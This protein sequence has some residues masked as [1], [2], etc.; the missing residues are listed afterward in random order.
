MASSTR[1]WALPGAGA[2]LGVLIFL[3]I[4][5]AILHG[6]AP[7]HEAASG[8]VPVD[9]APSAVASEGT[10]IVGLEEG[11]VERLPV[12]PQR[13]GA[14]RG[15]SPVTARA[16][17]AVCVVDSEERPLE[18]AEVSLQ[19]RP[20]QM[21]S[22]SGEA[23]LEV[24]SADPEV[25]ELAV[26]R[27]GFVAVRQLVSRFEPRVNVCLERG[28]TLTGVVV[29][30]REVPVADA[31][32]EAWEAGRELS[33]RLSSG[34]TD[35]S[36]RFVLEGLESKPIE[37]SVQPPAPL[38]PMVIRPDPRTPEPLHIVLVAGVPMEVLLLDPRGTPCGGVTV[39]A[40]FPERSRLAARTAVTDASG[41]ARLE[42]LPGDAG[43]LYLALRG[44]GIAPE[45]RTV[46]SPWPSKIEIA[47]EPGATIRGYFSGELADWG[48]IEVR[49]LVPGVGLVRTQ[50]DVT[51]AFELAHLPAD[52]PVRLRVA[53]ERPPPSPAL[54]MPPFA[55]RAG[56]VR[57]VRI[58]LPC[59]HRVE[60]LV[61]EASGVAIEECEVEAR[62]AGSKRPDGTS[63][64]ATFGVSDTEGRIVFLL[65]PGPWKV[66]AASTLH[67]PQELE[68]PPPLPDS[69]TLTLVRKSEVCGRVLSLCGE[70]CAQRQVRAWDGSCYRTAL[71]TSDGCFR[72]LGIAP[73]VPIDLVVAGLHGEAH[74]LALS[75]FVFPARVPAEIV[76]AEG[77]LEGRLVGPDE[78][79]V[80]GRV[81]LAKRSEKHLP[82]M[83]CEA[84]LVL[85]CD[86]NGSFRAEKLSLGWWE[87]RAEA[88]ELVFEPLS[89]NLTAAGAMQ[90]VLVR[91]EHACWLE[92]RA[93]ERNAVRL[94]LHDA[95]GAPL[96]TDIYVAPAHSKVLG[97][98]LPGHYL[99]EIRG[100]AGSRQVD[101]EIS[102]AHT[103]VD[104][105]A[106]GGG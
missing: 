5:H 61:R 76:F 45:D 34:R 17:L 37:L 7:L 3:V 59:R 31:M 106:S 63:F 58:D 87:L 99:L 62:P 105:R 1:V 2:V 86:V 26:V 44:K 49:A 11:A 57:G 8:L 47:L 35:T 96:W 74:G 82:T 91:G 103:V 68:L 101:L 32:I 13:D 22:R 4:R 81:V 53:A 78:R 23:V 94:T 24:E 77:A 50:P 21:T 55:L 46:S 54:E 19:D 83:G 60:V 18:R 92:V 90:Q 75:D 36:G 48:E 104:L 41:L 25:I 89:V 67:E 27:A 52:T 16:S 71:T 15:F 38:A 69:V 72:I 6:E 100:E 95:S 51:G 28:A 39:H 84:P 30:E 20:P 98:L 97:P 66:R 73:G 10:A 85:T 33:D 93:G 40:T 65:P 42:G 29:D 79:P 80:A 70:G 14:S 12:I 43:A 88:P 102:T 9:E 64:G 56:E